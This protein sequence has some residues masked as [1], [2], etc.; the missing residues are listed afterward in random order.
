M[1]ASQLFPV[2]FLLVLVCPSQN[3]FIKRDNKLVDLSNLKNLKIFEYKTSNEKDSINFITEIDSVYKTGDTLFVRPFAIDE[4]H[5]LDPNADV[6][7]TR[8]FKET[9]RTIVKIP[10]DNIDQLVGK[11]R[12]VSRI[13]SWV[14]SI[15]FVSI[16]A[17]IPLRLGNNDDNRAVGNAIF[18]TAAPTLILS[19]TLSA[20]VAKKHYHFNKSRT[21]KKIWVF[22]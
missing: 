1:R 16:A 9:S 12:S 3:V 11:K 17:S 4:V 2:F 19:W 10:I 8:I 7:V 20:T 13:L 6:T 5:Y 18:L 22:N 14:S 21:D 15:A